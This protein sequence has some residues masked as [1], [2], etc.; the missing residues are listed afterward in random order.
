MGKSVTAPDRQREDDAR[1]PEK[2]F[3]IGED[4]EYA[5]G[6]R[7]RHKHMGYTCHP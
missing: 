3:D 5:L 7:V 2:L 4:I 1:A 6:P